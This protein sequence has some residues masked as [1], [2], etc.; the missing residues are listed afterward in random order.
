MFFVTCASAVAAAA[1]L[2]LNLFEGG[3]VG[4]CGEGCSEGFSVDVPRV[5]VAVAPQ[6][7]LCTAKISDIAAHA[8]VVF[9]STVA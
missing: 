2:G 6:L 8:P 3:P 9:D 1:V 4:D 7:E 5:V